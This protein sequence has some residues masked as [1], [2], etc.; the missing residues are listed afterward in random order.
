M[1]Q[2]RSQIKTVTE[3]ELQGKT[4]SRGDDNGEA[5]GGAVPPQALFFMLQGSGSETGLQ[6]LNKTL[7]QCRI[8]V[9]TGI[10]PALNQLLTFL[11]RGQTFT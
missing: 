7:L 5:H 10:Q 6:C 9:A 2:K 3:R 4:E 11:C 1:C 8:A